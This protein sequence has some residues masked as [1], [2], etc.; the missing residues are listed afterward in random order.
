MTVNLQPSPIMQGCCFGNSSVDN[1]IP[2]CYY[3]IDS[4]QDLY[5][6][7]HGHG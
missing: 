4:Y 7:G 2:E 3:G 1:G 6:F 5:F